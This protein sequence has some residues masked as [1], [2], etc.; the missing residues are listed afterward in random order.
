MGGAE[1]ETGD[2][3]TVASSA[4]K[5]YAQA[6]FNLGKERGTLDQ[7]Q[8]DLALLA[9]M[10]ADSRIATYLTNPSVSAENKIAAI[11]SAMAEWNV[12]PETHN[13]ARMLV[14]RDRVNLVPEIRE[15]FDDQMRAEH[16]IVV[17]QVTT[18]EPLSDAERALVQDKLENLTGKHVQLEAR[19]DPDLI[20]GIIIRIG[21]EVIDGSVRN[22][23]EKLRS[24]LVAGRR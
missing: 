6:V 22:K 1:T 9:S 23:L 20:G 18:A 3:T 13:L 4:A 16:D 17:A 8:G 19:V 15:L 7:W 10:V 14:E 5:R 24:R 21:D 2:K 11:E 12:Q